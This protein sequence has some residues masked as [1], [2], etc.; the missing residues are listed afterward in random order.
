M[1]TPGANDASDEAARLGSGRASS[2]WRVTTCATVDVSDSTSGGAAA[3]TL[4]V[5][6]VPATASMMSMASV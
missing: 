1:I 3:E 6:D 2:I 4:T 5:S